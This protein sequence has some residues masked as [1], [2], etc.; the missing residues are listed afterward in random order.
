[1]AGVP[2][3]KAIMPWKILS[4]QRFQVFLFRTA[5]EHAGLCAEIPDMGL[6]SIRFDRGCICTDYIESQKLLF[7]RA[8]HG[9][10]GLG[11]F[12]TEPVYAPGRKVEPVSGKGVNK[13]AATVIRNHA[14]TI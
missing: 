6:F 4:P 7:N 1:M 14:F 9:V 13:C 12:L 5:V 8:L 3:S 11:K 2:F 10:T